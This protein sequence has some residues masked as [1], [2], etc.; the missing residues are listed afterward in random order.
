M[1]I[2]IPGLVA[3]L[4]TIIVVAWFGWLAW[5]FIVI[6]VGWFYLVNPKAKYEEWKVWREFNAELKLWNSKARR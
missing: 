2:F 3:F 6:L 5:A 4:T 1:G